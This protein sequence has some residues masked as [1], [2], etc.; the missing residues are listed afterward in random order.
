MPKNSKLYADANALTDIDL[1]EFCK[2]NG[3]A[4]HL[5]DLSKLEEFTERYGFV[6][7]GDT[8]DEYN[9]GHPHHWLFLDGNDLFDSYGKT[10]DEYKLPKHITVL[11]NHPNRLQAYNTVVCG[12]YCCAFYKFSHSWTPPADDDINNTTRR[13]SEYFSIEHNFNN[14]H[15]QNDQK[16]WDWYRQ[17]GGQLP[18]SAT[19]TPTDN[20]PTETPA[21]TD[22]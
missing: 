10:S 9:K 4:F 13:I 12:Q 14:N 17:N 20:A 19:T 11:A 6:F 22:V 2:T 15:E 21:E 3:L 1:K 16:V 8:N 7:T 18:Q 5:C